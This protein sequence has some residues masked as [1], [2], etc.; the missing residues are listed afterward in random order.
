M[1]EEYKEYKRAYKR[2][3]LYRVYEVS[4]L[5]NVKCNGVLIE[6]IHK[7]YS[8]IGGFAIHRAVA[9]LFIPNPENKPCVDHIDTNKQNNRADNLRWVT[10]EENLLNPISR[11]RRIK[12]LKGR[13]MPDKFG[14]IQSKIKLQLYKNNPELKEKVGPKRGNHYPKMT[15][16]ALNKPP[17]KEET[18]QKLSLLFSGEN[19]PMYGKK[20]KDYMTEEEY[21]NWKNNLKG[22]TPWNKGKKCENLSG[23][24]NGMYGKKL[25]DYM[26]EEKYNQMIA[27]RSGKNS[28]MFGK[29]LRRWVNKDGIRH[30]IKKEEL[31][32][33]LNSGWKKG[34]N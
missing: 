23:E 10:P 19:N 1:I 34:K 2:K 24:N 21:D 27:K 11:E 13:K 18:K 12:A 33:Y 9:E 32:N 31:D 6:P 29:D 20:L 7:G 8:H 25:K 4:N 26:T 30:L 16:A 15:E 14:E 28:G 3:C 5:G 22:K 17:V